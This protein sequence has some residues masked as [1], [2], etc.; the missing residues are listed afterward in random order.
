MVANNRK[1]VQLVIFEQFIFAPC[2]GF[3]MAQ[4]KN[5]ACS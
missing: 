1:K 5:I 2:E 4:Y 3:A